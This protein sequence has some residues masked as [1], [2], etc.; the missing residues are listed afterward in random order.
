MIARGHDGI[1]LTLLYSS[2]VSSATSAPGAF[3]R[4][5]RFTL[6]PARAI[7]SPMTTS[8]LLLA[9]W[10]LIFG[11]GLLLRALNLRHLKRYGAVVPDGFQD[12][13]NQ[14]TLA[15]TSAYTLEQSRVGLVESIPDAALLI[16]FLFGGLLPRYDQWV[17][18]LTDSFILR[19]LL[20]FLILS[21]VQLIVSIPFSLYSTFR[22]EARYGFNTTTPRIWFT[23]LVKSTLLSLL[24][25]G[26]LLSG[27]LALV[28]AS[29]LRWWL[30]VWLFFACV[31]IFLMYLSP[32][33]IEPLFNKFEPVTEEGLAEE[34]TALMI[35]GGLTVSKVQQVDA[36]KRSRHSNAYFTGIGRVK[37]IVLYDT[38]ISRMSHREILAVLAH[39]VGHWKLGHIRQRLIMTEFSALAISFLSWWLIG[40][41]L[42][43]PLFGLPPA[44]E[45]SFM[46]QLLL[47]SFLGT[48]AGFP[49]TPLS[50]WLS[51]RHEWQADRFAMKLC[52]DPGALASALV[53]LS[54]ENL[55][56]FHPHPFYALWHYSHPPVVQRVAR[57][58]EG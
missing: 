12:A 51:R 13:V 45:S 38:L 22:L 20:F 6:L 15:K 10:L 35:K 37:R 31:T 5:S 19:G 39:E 21:G 56:N 32:Y 3:D 40:S 23:D 30:W 52:N 9:A 41:G 11:F 54:T 50:S 36:S 17:A 49:L 18:T 33:V 4:F 25:M 26:L 42:L 29:P 53:K 44:P 58:R 28:Q 46:A 8:H 2:P 47:L 14:A 43:P 57:L 55:S 1:R 34:I 7:I 16:L 24:L 48:L 27:A